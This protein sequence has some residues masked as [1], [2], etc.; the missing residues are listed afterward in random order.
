MTKKIIAITGS[1]NQTTQLHKV[2]KCLPD[3]EFYFTQFFGDSKIHKFIAENG[4]MNNTIIGVESIFAKSSRDYIKEQGLNYDYRGESLGNKY[5]LVLMSTDL[6]IPTKFKKSKKVW[7]QE[8]MIDKQTILSKIVKK[9]HVAPYLAMNTSLN[10]TTNRCDIY[11]AASEG[12]KDYLSKNGTDRNKIMVTGIP[13][14]D[15]A[16]QYLINDFPK[17]HFILVATSDIR[18]LNGKEDRIG[19]LEKCKEIANGKEII[20]KLHPNEKYE[21]AV[22]EIGQVL[23]KETLVYTFGDINQMI[24][25]CDE[26]ITQYSSCVYMGIALQKKVHSYFNVE[27]L[28]SQCPIQNDGTSAKSIANIIGEFIEFDGNGKEFLYQCNEFCLL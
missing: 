20:V 19:F 15:N 18:E 27:Q 6:L 14:F 25:N 23:G 16:K 26:L 10:G 28:K 13:N 5:D 4:I 7:I 22:Y 24:A 1:L 21:R 17:H 2:S 9:T 8:G 12:Y 3:Y 11:C